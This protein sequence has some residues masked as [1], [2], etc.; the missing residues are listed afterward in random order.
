MFERLE[1]RR[2]LSESN[3]V[4]VIESYPGY[5]EIHGGDEPN[6]VSASVSMSEESLT[7]DGQTYYGVSYVYVNTY[8]G[9]DII[10]IVSVDGAGSIGA[11]IDAGGNCDTITLNF[12]GAIW[13]GTGD[14]VLFLTDSF[15]GQAHGENG[16]DQMYIIGACVDPEI[17]GGSGDDLIDC[18]NN[19]YGV[20]AHG[21]GGND[22][23]YGSAFDDLIYGGDGNDSMV[24]GGGND[25]FLTGSGDGDELDGGDGYDIIYMCDGGNFTAISIEEMA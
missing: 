18:R 22:T 7:L 19:Y 25:G 6:Y 21:G 3:G 13:A 5:Y 14:D 4:T 16:D 11:Y 8:G 1:S 12:D 2:L 20:V 9:D 15:R 23:I 10:S 24:G 17:I